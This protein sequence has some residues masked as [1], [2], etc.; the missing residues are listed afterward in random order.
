MFYERSA[1][2]EAD[3]QLL[4]D[5]HQTI[6]QKEDDARITTSEIYQN[7]NVA[8]IFGSWKKLSKKDYKQD[9]AP[10]HILKNDVVKQHG[11]RPLVIIETPLLNRKIGRRHDYYRVGLNHYLNNL[12]E[13]NNKDCKPDRFNKLGLT[14]KPWRSKGEHIL[15]LGQNL[16]DASLLGADMELWVIT[17]IK[18]LLKHTKRPIHFRD[19]PENGRKLQWAITRN[20]HDIKQVKYDESKTIK[21]SLQNAH[22]CVAYTSGSSLD[23]ILDGVPVIP[24]SQYNFVWDIS[25]HSLNE[26]EN[27]KMGEREQLLYNLAYAQW[28]VKEIKEGKA[29]D[30]LNEYINRHN[31]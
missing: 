15:V 30:H 6:A 14:I 3:R 11:Q 7:C 24:T 2:A 17:T 23:A 9:R 26:I 22:C 16:N 29:W 20:F 27:P 21:D 4:R 8:V 18:H 5:F 19:H 1:V 25:S 13:F 10:H 31:I 28:S 12:G